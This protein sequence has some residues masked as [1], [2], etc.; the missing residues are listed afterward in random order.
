MRIHKYYVSQIDEQDCGVA[1]LAT[2]LK[3]YGSTYSIAYLRHLAKTNLEG[4]TALGLVK[5]AQK[6][7]FDTKAIKANMSLFKIK[8]LP[9]PFIAHVLKKNEFYHFYVICKIHKNSLT[10]A[11]PDPDDGIRRISKQQFRKEWTGVALFMAPNASYKPVKKNKNSLWN[12]THILFK[13][14]SLITHIIIA[15]FL[16]TIISIVGS[17]YFQGLLDSFIPSQAITT[18][19]TISIGL[20]TAYVLQQILTFGQN[21]LLTILGQRLSIDV[22]LSYIKHIFKLPM[23]FF[24]TRRT[25]EIVSRFTDSN[26]IIDALASTIITIFLDSFIVIILA[27]VLAAQ[28]LPLFLITLLLIPLYTLVIYLFVKPFEKYNQATM[29]TN[30]Q[31]SS[32]IIEDINGIETIKSLNA[33]DNSYGRIDH[34][35]V[36]LLDKGFTYSKLSI[37]Q[38]VIK[39]GIQLTMN[40]IILWVGSKLVIDNV[41]SVGQLITYNALLSYFINPIQNIIN[42]QNKLQSARVAN[43]RLN[44]VYLVKSEFKK[45]RAINYIKPLIGNITIKNLQYNYGYSQPVLKNINLKI[46]PNEKIALIGMSGSG[47]TTL[48]QLLAGFY[49]IKK[50]QILLGGHSIEQVN[51]HTIRNYINYVPQ[52]PYLFN[53]TILENLTL[54]CR[55]NITFKD[56][57]HACQLAEIN[58]DIKKRPLQYATK[59]SE[60]G[61]ILSGG[62]KQR[63]T[64]ARALLTPAK[65]LIFDESTSALDSITENKVIKNLMTLKSRTIIFIAHR[66]NIAKQV[67]KI[68]ILNNGKIINQGTHQELL[69]D[70]PFYRSLL[71]N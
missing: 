59:L 12:Y 22:I 40:I 70:S 67:N 17:Y 2:I 34:E 65:V 18:I 15:S 45:K 30:A 62:Q 68:L 61:T 63:L 57:K 49:P 13:Q 55:G 11:D 44:E 8:H 48:S 64:I 71:N 21:Y 16:I 43:N 56:V 38:Q 20:I 36:K 7:N 24:A 39:S 14:K 31:L 9:M 54:G 28:S 53:G 26:K 46:H 6:L 60:D 32:G 23:S 27:I 19:S 52:T 25:G 41:L 29:E 4:T 50:G 51:R 58:S 1:A 42:L 37:L 10:I 66:L 47:K 5:A 33:E 69:K 35:F 3:R